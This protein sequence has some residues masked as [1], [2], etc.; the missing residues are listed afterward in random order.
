MTLRDLLLDTLR[1]LW[2]HKL[3]TALTMF[4]IGW[5]IVSITL[6]VA[7]GEGL[8]AGLRQGAGGL[9]QRTADHQWRAH[10]PASRRD[11]LGAKNSV[12]GDR[13]P[14]CRSREATACQYVIPERGRGGAR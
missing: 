2:T 5:G 10:Q 3:R 8:R 9:R 14:G 12:D 11:A 6:M 13:P 4:G 1:T 7:A